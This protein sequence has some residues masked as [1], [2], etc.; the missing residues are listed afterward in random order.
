MK[1]MESIGNVYVTNQYHCQLGFHR[2]GTQE[3]AGEWGWGKVYLG[4]RNS[5]CLLPVITLLY[6]HASIISESYPL[7]IQSSSLQ[8]R[9]FLPYSH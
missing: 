9:E 2:C 3:G 7:W 5:L 8:I 1:D 4:G 6:A